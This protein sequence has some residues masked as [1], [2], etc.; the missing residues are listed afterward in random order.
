MY[1]KA[2]ALCAGYFKDRLGSYNGLYYLIAGF[3]IFMVILWTI[4][5]AAEPIK[6]MLLRRRRAKGFR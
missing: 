5:V 4:I 3:C 2:L 6:R 1:E